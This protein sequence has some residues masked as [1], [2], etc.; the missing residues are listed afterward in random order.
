MRPLIKRVFGRIVTETPYDR[1]W[2]DAIKYVIP[3]G[4]RTYEESKVWSFDP[5]YYTAVRTITEHFFGTKIIDSTGGVAEPQT[6]EWKERWEVWKSSSHSKSQS[7]PF[8]GM[9][10]EE[11]LRNKQ[12]S[13]EQR[14]R[15]STRTAS[16]YATLFLTEDA[17]KEVITAAWRALCAAN[18]PDKGGSHEVMSRING[19][20]Q[21]LKKLGKV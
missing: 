8:D 19:A 18:H 17:P 9:D 3:L 7:N 13:R 4:S 20:Y 2:V 16:A 5:R 12:G 6:N 11:I 1:L 10:W 21:E 15:S 14:P